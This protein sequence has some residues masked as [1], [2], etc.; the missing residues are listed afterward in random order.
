MTPLRLT[1]MAIMLQEEHQSPEQRGVGW[2]Y[3]G[4]RCS[5][6]TGGLLSLASA[7]LHIGRWGQPQDL[8]DPTVQV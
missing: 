7:P 3:V 1:Q 4:C 6:G 8:R 2:V 5:V